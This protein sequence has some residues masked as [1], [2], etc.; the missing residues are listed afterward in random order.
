MIGNSSAIDVINNAHKFE[1]TNKKI[2]FNIFDCY[3]SSI[4]DEYLNLIMK[5]FKNF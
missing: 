4:Y 2:G 1:Q 3:D 5:S